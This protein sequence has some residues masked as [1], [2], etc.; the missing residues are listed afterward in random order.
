MAGRNVIVSGAASGIGFACADAER[1]G[2]RDRP[3]PFGEV[4]HALSVAE[5]RAIAYSV[6][7]LAMRRLPLVLALA[8]MGLLLRDVHPAAAPQAPAAAGTAKIKVDID[9]AIG[10]VDPLLFGSFTEHLGRMIYG[11]IYEEGSPLSD[12]SGYRKDVLQ[13]VK[14]LGMSII[15]WPGGNFVSSYN[16]YDGIGP[17]SQRPGRL[18]LAWN[19]VESNRFGTDE[20]LQWTALTG[21]EPYICVN[22]GLGTVDD[23]RF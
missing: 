2:D 20:F 19:D 5:R 11:G 8:V 12:A 22:L 9:R 10:T 7:S 23:A 17:K 14:D 6:Y 13:A 1:G 21:A 4:R 18:D 15:R 3:L 16:W